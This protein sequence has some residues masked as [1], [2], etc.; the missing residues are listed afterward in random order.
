M[1][2]LTLGAMSLVTQNL[3]EYFG[4]FDEIGD[5]VDELLTPSKSRW[6]AIA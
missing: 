2:C 4:A 5:G 3:A 6:K 1:S